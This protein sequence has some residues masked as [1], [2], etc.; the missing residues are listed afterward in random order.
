MCPPQ[1]EPASHS[2]TVFFRV[3][4]LDSPHLLQCGKTFKLQMSSPIQGLSRHTGRPR[5]LGSTLCFASP[6]CSPRKLNFWVFS[7]RLNWSVFLAR[8]IEHSAC[9]HLSYLPPSK[10]PEHW[11]DWPFFLFVRRLQEV[12]RMGWPWA[13]VC[14]TCGRSLLVFLSVWYPHSLLLSCVPGSRLALK[15]EESSCHVSAACLWGWMATFI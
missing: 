3:L 11:Q 14:V 9:A 1:R 4:S 8:E 7:H 2:L 10:T 12:R 15:W 6:P 13:Q 5:G